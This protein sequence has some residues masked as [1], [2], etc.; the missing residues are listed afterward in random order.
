MVTM[1]GPRPRAGLALLPF[2]QS[3]VVQPGSVVVDRRV[4][5]LVGGPG[6]NRRLGLRETR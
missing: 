4:Y 1:G 3:R 6:T 5:E 2:M